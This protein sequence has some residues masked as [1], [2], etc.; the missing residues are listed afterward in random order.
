MRHK[1]EIPLA[2][3]HRLGRNLEADR[4]V[5]PDVDEGNVKNRGGEQKIQSEE[6]KR[7]VSEWCQICHLARHSEGGNILKNIRD[8]LGW[9]DPS[10]SAQIMHERRQREMK[11][12]KEMRQKHNHPPR[13]QVN[14]GRI[15]D[16]DADLD[17]SFT[18]KSGVDL[19]GRLEE[20]LYFGL[21]SLPDYGGA[22]DV[23]NGRS[24][25]SLRAVGSE[26]ES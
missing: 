9:S 14:G 21:Q 23:G 22:I 20:L 3:M 19:I 18:R 13:Q 15:S 11:H 1:E 6:S 2:V 16:V 4:L 24:K 10:N 7:D 26:N 12:G 8:Q 5:T 25:K 17:D